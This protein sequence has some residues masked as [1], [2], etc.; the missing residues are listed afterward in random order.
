MA[1]AATGWK[2]THT[3]TITSQT[4]TT[5]TIKVTVYWQNDGWTY[6][7]SNVSASVICNGVTKDVFSS[8]NIKTTSSGTQQQELGSYSFTINKT[9]ASQSIRCYGQIRSASSYASGTRN[10]TATF[11]DVDPKT[12]Y[13]VSYN[14]NGGTDAPGAQIKTYGVTLTLSKTVPTRT[15]YTF[16]NWLSTTQNQT[17]APGGSYGHNAATTMKAQWTVNKY[18]IAYN[19]N[20]GTGAPASATKNH[21]ATY[22]ISNTEPTRTNYNFVGWATSPSA[23]VATYQGG[24]SYTTNA[25]LTLYAVWQLAYQPP[26]INNVEVYRCDQNGVATDN[27]TYFKAKFDWATDDEVNSINLSYWSLA[28][29]SNIAHVTI[30]GT[31]SSSPTI[32]AGTYRFNDITIP[33]DTEIEQDLQFE[34]TTEVQGV[35]VVT[36]FCHRIFVGKCSSDSAYFTGIQYYLTSTI[37]S[38]DLSQWEYI[39]ASEVGGW[40]TET[41]GEGIQTITIPNDTE[42]S[43]EFYEWFTVNIGTVETGVLGDGNISIDETWNV[44]IEVDDGPDHTNVTRTLSN[45]ACPIDAVYDTA[46]KQVGVALGKTATRTGV[47]ESA[48]PIEINQNGVQTTIKSD[49]IYFSRYESTANMGNFFTKPIYVDGDIYKYSWTEGVPH[50]KVAYTKCD[51]LWTGN[52]STVNTTISVKYDTSYTGYVIVGMMGTG[53]SESQ[54]ISSFIPTV[55]LLTT[56]TEWRISSDSAYLDFA[57]RQNGTYVYVVKKAGAN[58][59]SLI[60]RI[61][62]VT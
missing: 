43:A 14:A 33:P 15:G 46:T 54:W 29:P 5:V 1:T 12:T 27:G 44:E 42:V 51:Q 49:N 37:P 36:A 31:G 34:V 25:P 61:Y 13:I 26:R 57:I 10:S 18:T 62:G 2:C 3:A 38:M 60:I 40:F 21:G 32:K 53:G 16:N 55:S 58:S 23:T 19:A 30:G 6:N 22:T 45:I 39:W 35:G 50:Q 17:Y 48:L 47:V 4:E 28:N 8:G 59:D 9:S 41:Y 20:G 52:M 11:V 24:N 56:Q 7:I